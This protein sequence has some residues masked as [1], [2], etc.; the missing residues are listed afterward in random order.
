VTVIPLVMLMC[1]AEAKVV[2]A[3]WDSKADDVVAAARAD[4]GAIVVNPLG[5]Q[6]ACTACAR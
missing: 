3:Y 2:H 4:L 5:F 6:G 1:A